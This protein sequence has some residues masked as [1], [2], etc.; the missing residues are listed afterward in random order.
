MPAKNSYKLSRPR[1]IALAA[2]TIDGKIAK[3]TKHFSN[4]TSPED[5]IFLR[6]M[7]DKSDVIIVG[8]NTY[9]TAK[10]PLSKRNCIVLTSSVTT[11]AQKNSNL[12]FFN[13]KFA[14]LKNFIKNQGYKTVAILGGAQTY[15]YCLSQGMLDDLYLTI[16]PITFG[17]GINLFDGA[18]AKQKRWK[19]VSIKNLNRTGTLLL[20]YRI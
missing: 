6:R 17:A 13:P 20:H 7:L 9:K 8:N 1:Y 10:K 4:W 14:N 11:P 3:N 18:R 5:K 19:L 12:A 15:G 16:E 2:V